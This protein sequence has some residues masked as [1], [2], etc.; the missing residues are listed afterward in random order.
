MEKKLRHHLKMVYS[1]FKYK[2]YNQKNQRIHLLKF[3]KIID[4]D[5][6]RYVVLGT[7]K[8]DSGYSPEHLKSMYGLADAVLRNADTFYICYRII[9]AEFEMI[10][11]Q[12]T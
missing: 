1:L 2:K 10:E 12:E 5:K 7:A 8:V 11:N 9:D 6:D 4:V 3:P